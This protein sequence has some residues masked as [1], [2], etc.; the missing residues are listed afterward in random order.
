M[1][2]AA[3]LSTM[4]EVHGGVAGGARDRGPDDGD[5]G[6]SQAMDVSMYRNHM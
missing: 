6:Q 2:V 1:H 4:A 3:R 5:L